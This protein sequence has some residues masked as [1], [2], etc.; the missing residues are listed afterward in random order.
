MDPKAEKTFL[1]FL[2]LFLAVMLISNVARLILG[3][4]SANP[5][6]LICFAGGLICT[7]I[8]WIQYF[9]RNKQDEE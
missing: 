7:V 2:T 4:E 8:A 3:S 5:L 9:R 6:M 1:F